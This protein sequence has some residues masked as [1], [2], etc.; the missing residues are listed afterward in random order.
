MAQFKRIK[1]SRSDLTIIE[2]IGKLTLGELSRFLDSLQ[3]DNASS[4][5]IFDF[6]AADLSALAKA[7]IKSEIRKLERFSHPELKAALVFSNPT[8]FSTG[9]A[10]SKAVSKEGYLADIRGFYN[11]YLAKDWLL[12]QGQSTSL[13]PATQ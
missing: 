4:R 7:C 9:K 3:V 2:I 10:I 6:R 8:D 13:I 1:D 5:A 11:L 12:Y